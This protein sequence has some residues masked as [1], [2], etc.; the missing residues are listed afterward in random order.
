MKLVILL[1][2]IFFYFKSN[3]Q[4]I[5]NID[6]L[7]SEKENIKIIRFGNLLKTERQNI[8]FQSNFINQIKLKF[9]PYKN[10]EFKIQING[11]PFEKKKL[12]LILTN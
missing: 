1:V 3:S 8:I 11:D 12:T 4:V 7:A 10:D 5:V 9:K 2:V 6:K